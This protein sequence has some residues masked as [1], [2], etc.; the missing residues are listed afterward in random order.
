M[1]LNSYAKCCIA[2]F[3]HLI[4]LLAAALEGRLLDFDDKVRTEAVFAVCDLA[5]S[6]LTCFPSEIILQA[7]ERLRDKKVTSFQFLQTESSA[8]VL[9][10]VL[11]CRFLLERK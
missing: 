3:L 8:L 2:N 11:F 9:S 1:P 10:H 6:S 5:K 4:Y 7:V